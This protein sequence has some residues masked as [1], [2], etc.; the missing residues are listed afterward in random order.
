[1]AAEG[2]D[3]V[4]RKSIDTAQRRRLVI[5]YRL[6]GMTYW[7]IADR[8]AEEIP[9]EDLPSGWDSRYAWKD[10]HRELEHIRDDILEDME[11]VLELEKRRLDDLQ[12]ALW[13]R[14]IGDKDKDPDQ[15]A[16]DRI[17][18]IMQ[19]RA[20]LYG[21]DAPETLKVE[22]LLEGEL[23]VEDERIARSLEELA[24]ALG[25]GIPSESDG[26]ESVVGSTVEETVASVS[27]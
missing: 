4:K 21:L 3:R 19:R 20:R 6:K 5:K 26:K 13:D 11:H 18:K 24:K 9:R 23:K 7:D 1:M 16:I 27:D 14:A 22:A 12:A 25:E 10:F 15:S 17:L 2:R 8:I